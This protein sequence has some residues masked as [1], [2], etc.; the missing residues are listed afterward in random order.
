[1]TAPA[2]LT[3]VEFLMTWYG[4]PLT[5]GQRTLVRVAIDRMA[6][7]DLPEDERAIALEMFGDLDNAP[8]IAWRT[9]VLQCGRSGGKTEICSGIALYLM[10]TVD[11]SKCG[12]G[13]VPRAFV[14][15]V[16]L[17]TARLSVQRAVA[18]IQDST[19]LGELLVGAPGA[20][21][22]DLRRPHDGRVVR[23]EVR[24]AS[25]GGRSLRGRSI[26]CLICDEAAFFTSEGFVVNDREI[27]KAVRPR[28][29]RGGLILLASTP[30]SDEGLFAELC[31]KN[32]K[33]ATS[34]IVAHAPTLVLR[35]NDPEL[36]ELIALERAED[37][38]TA[39]R[40]Y[41]AVFNLG[42]SSAFFDAPS[43]AA[44]VRDF[45]D[46][47]DYPNRAAGAD[48]GL[49]RDSSAMVV[50]GRTAPESTGNHND[51]I[52]AHEARILP[53]EIAVLSITELRPTKVQPLKLSLV[54]GTFAE[55]MKAH[56]VNEV[57]ADGHN[58]ESAREYADLHQIKIAAAPEGNAGKFETYVLTRKLFR[59]GRLVVPRH[60]RLMAQL[61]AVRSK[62]LP[63]GGYQLIS[64]RSAGGGHGDL[65]SALVLGVFGSKSSSYD[66]LLDQ[67]AKQFASETKRPQVDPG[68][69]H[70]SRM[71]KMPKGG[72]CEAN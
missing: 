46:P 17:D 71:F 56:G 54:I 19:E 65:V 58:R 63:G 67:I 10:L 15:S 14:V 52:R 30:W 22:F 51:A 32:G 33:N 8:A 1:M 24:S 72:N 26:I 41:D 21:S 20:D 55:T 25:R 5:L 7:A 60:A 28:L 4:L 39:E 61:R 66:I 38:E 23:F 69:E 6:I 12:P 50:T 42:G 49:V 27:V 47:V 18:R 35:D 37:P 70:M 29:L 43:L 9:I 53:F 62:P 48:I 31:E 13:D 64:P 59:E 2:R 34:A 45:I 68:F 57:L 36:A 3:C 11:V 40:E 44:A 16:D